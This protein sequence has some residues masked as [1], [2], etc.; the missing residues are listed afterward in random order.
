M[1][2]FTHKS[3]P[4]E[5]SGVLVCKIQHMQDQGLNLLSESK[6]SYIVCVRGNGHVFC[7]LNSKLICD[8][9]HEQI[10]AQKKACSTLLRL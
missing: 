9:N 10:A 8:T 7:Y 1:L 4:I 2:N 6:S 3:S 5:L